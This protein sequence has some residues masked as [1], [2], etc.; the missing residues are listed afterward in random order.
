MQRLLAAH[1]VIDGVWAANDLMALGA[2]EAL[3]E[4][5]RTA[6]VV[7]VNGLPAAIDHIEQGTM[8]ASADFSAFN[9]ATIAARA[10]LRHLAGEPVPKQILIP[11]RL[12]DRTNH[13]AWQV[14]FEAR[15]LAAWEDVV[16]RCSVTT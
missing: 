16:G 11:A 9:I 4:A 12:I 1:S 13:R 14:P 5:G 3:A 15:P 6:K 2:L 10:A 8:L 7:G